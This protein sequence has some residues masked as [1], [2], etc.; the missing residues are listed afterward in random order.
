MSSNQRI[1]R[2]RFRHDQ[3]EEPLRCD[4][5]YAVV[6]DT[7]ERRS[8]FCQ[9]RLVSQVLMRP[10]PLLQEGPSLDETQLRVLQNLHQ[11]IGLEPGRC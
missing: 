3:R 6:H 11:V 7:K 8:T 9:Q 1:M 5:F 10:A 2:N 4:E